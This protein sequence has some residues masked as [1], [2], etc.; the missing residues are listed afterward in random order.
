[1]QT[2]LCDQCNVTLDDSDI[3]ECKTCHGDFCRDCTTLL[4]DG[5]CYQCDACYGLNLMTAIPRPT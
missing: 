4:V 5:D 2:W 1:M 3:C